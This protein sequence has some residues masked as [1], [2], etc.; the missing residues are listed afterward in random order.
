MQYALQIT[1]FNM[2]EPNSFKTKWDVEEITCRYTFILLLFILVFGIGKLKAKLEVPLVFDEHL[3][4]SNLQG[5]AM[6]EEEEKKV[7]ESNGEDC[8]MLL[9]NNIEG[10]IIKW[11]YQVHIL[12]SE[13]IYIYPVSVFKKNWRFL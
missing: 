10:I 8:D 7:R 4:L 11:A 1:I 6:I 9:K 12:L 13:N 2:D 5:A 3:N